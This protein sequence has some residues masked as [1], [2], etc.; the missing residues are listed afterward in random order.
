MTRPAAREIVHP[1]RMPPGSR[2]QIA[3]CLYDVHRR[4]FAETRR[5][6]PRDACGH[7]DPACP[8]SRA[9]GRPAG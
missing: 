8:R 6:S 9:R 4:I 7:P 5:P 3:D 2:S 1:Q